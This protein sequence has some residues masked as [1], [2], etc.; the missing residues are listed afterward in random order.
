MRKIIL[1]ALVAVAC[2]SGCASQKYYYGLQTNGT[3]GD[4]PCVCSSE[5][6][7]AIGGE[8]AFVDQIDIDMQ[9]G[10]LALVDIGC[11]AQLL[12]LQRNGGF[13]TA[14]HN[15]NRRTT[16]PAGLLNPIRIRI[17]AMCSSRLPPSPSLHLA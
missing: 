8:H 11:F 15:P 7:L 2:T 17:G 13:K 4:E 14:M 1:V 10:Y 12:Q 16:R 9:F 3:F 5:N 6:P